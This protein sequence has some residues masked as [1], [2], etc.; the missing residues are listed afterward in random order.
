L[1]SFFK[2]YSRSAKLTQ[3]VE[4][5]V[6]KLSSEHTEKQNSSHHEETQILKEEEEEENGNVNEETKPLVLDP[7]E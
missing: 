4:D 7:K 2:K 3:R 6:I 5:A 1:F